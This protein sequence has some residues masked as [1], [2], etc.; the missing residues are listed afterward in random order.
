MSVALKSFCR[1]LPLEAIN[2]QQNRMQRRRKLALALCHQTIRQFSQN[3][4]AEVGID[5][6]GAGSLTI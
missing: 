6:E 5:R 4:A 2:E 1:Q 3:R